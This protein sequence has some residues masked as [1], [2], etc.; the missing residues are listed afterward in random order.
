MFTKTNKYQNQ[1]VVLKSVKLKRF[2]TMKYKRD[3]TF[4]YTEP[5]KNA[6]S[7]SQSINQ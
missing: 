4:V 3:C 1:I 5:K 7:I 6:Q 2:E